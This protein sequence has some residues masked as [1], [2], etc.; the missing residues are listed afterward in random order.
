MPWIPQIQGVGAQLQRDGDRH[1]AERGRERCRAS[2]PPPFRRPAPFRHRKS[3]R[4]DGFRHLRRISGG[5]RVE[6]ASRQS[7][8]DGKTGSARRARTSDSRSLY[9]FLRR[10]PISARS[11]RAAAQPSTISSLL[12]FFTFRACDRTREKTFS[13]EC[14]LGRR[15]LGGLGNREPVEGERLLETIFE[16]GSR[17][18]AQAPRVRQG[19]LEGRLRVLA[20]LESPDVPGL[21][22]RAGLTAPQEGRRGRSSPCGCGSAGSRPP[23][24]TWPSPAS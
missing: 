1:E 7:P 11:G 12:E 22:A 21:T 18:L 5:C 17:R 9:A 2:S 23:S 16:A 20:S 14:V 13:I 24:R 19:R 4:G 6:T 10:K 15:T 8:R 3:H